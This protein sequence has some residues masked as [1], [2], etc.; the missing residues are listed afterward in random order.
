MRMLETIDAEPLAGVEYVSV[1]DGATLAELDRVTGPALLSLAVRFGSTRLIDNEPL[2]VARA[3]GRGLASAVWT[4]Y[5]ATHGSWRGTE[6]A[7]PSSVAASSSTASWPSS[8]PGTPT[9]STSCGPS[10]SAACVTSEGTIYPLLARLRRDGLVTTDWRESSA[11]PPRRYYRIT[12][13]GRRVLASFAVGVDRVSRHRRWTRSTLARWRIVMDS[14]AFLADTW[15]DW[16]RPLWL[17][18]CPDGSTDRA[19][20][21]RPA[22]TSS[23]RSPIV[24]PDADGRTA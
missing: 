24:G 9:R 12:D 13:D 19:P 22:S 18:T 7:R 10:G 16:T 21:G 3:P 5:L 6:A 1:A 4:R 15:L 20:L 17:P 23:S 14:D 2:G 11:G 8:S